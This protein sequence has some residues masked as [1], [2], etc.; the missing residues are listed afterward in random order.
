MSPMPKLTRGR[1]GFYDLKTARA[2]HPAAL[3][4]GHRLHVDRRRWNDLPD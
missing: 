3:V 4:R 1:D 2:Y